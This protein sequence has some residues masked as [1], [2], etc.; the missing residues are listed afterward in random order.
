[1]VCEPPLFVVFDITH[2][3]CFNDLQ[4]GVAWVLFIVG[5][6]L[7]ARGV[8]YEQYF[9]VA[10]CALFLLPF[11]LAVYRI[12]KAR[13]HAKLEMVRRA[14]ENERSARQENVI[15]DDDERTAVVTH[16]IVLS[17]LEEV[18]ETCVY[19]ASA[20]HMDRM[21]AYNRVASKI[22]QNEATTAATGA[23]G[24]GVEGNDADG[25]EGRSPNKPSEGTAAGLPGENE[26]DMPPAQILMSAARGLRG[27]TM[28][29]GLTEHMMETPLPCCSE[30]SLLLHCLHCTPQPSK[31]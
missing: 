7:T 28:R 23:N 19:G 27:N 24:K 12:A 11:L 25:A 16:H 13:Y 18:L 5:A 20:T 26:F 21:H 1:M 9:H 3:T 31:T 14:F 22:S 29:G 30:V 17:Y 8:V 2:M 4:V 10:F 15:L 6:A